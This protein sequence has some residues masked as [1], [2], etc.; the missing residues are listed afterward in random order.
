MT[1]IVTTS[2]CCMVYYA[3]LRLLS[4]SREQ[5]SIP[6]LKHIIVGTAVSGYWIALSASG[7]LD[8]LTGIYQIE[9]NPVYCCTV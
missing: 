6:I 9:A 4:S 3:F 2:V 7:V 1:L 8:F 5:Q